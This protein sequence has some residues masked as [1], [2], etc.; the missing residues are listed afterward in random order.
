MRRRPCKA[1][2]H[3]I[4]WSALVMDGANGNKVE[5]RRDSM[6]W[7]VLFGDG[8]RHRSGNIYCSIHS[9]KLSYYYPL[10]GAHDTRADK[11]VP[12]PS[13]LLSSPSAIN[14][15]RPSAFLILARYPL[16]LFCCHIMSDKSAPSQ[17]LGPTYRAEGEKP[18]ATVSK[19]VGHANV[20]VLPQTPQLIAL[21]T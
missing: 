20:H 8:R 11:K 9:P 7:L 1:D 16:L 6:F 17:C 5:G 21:L 19:K 10:C 2:S 4:K 13:Q 14:I 18:K 12:I 3:A 15:H